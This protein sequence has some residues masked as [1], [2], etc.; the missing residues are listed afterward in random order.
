MNDS[1]LVTTLGLSAYLCAKLQANCGSNGS[2]AE[3][4]NSTQL[5]SIRNKIDD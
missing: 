1:S 2:S 3:K 4:G 5:S